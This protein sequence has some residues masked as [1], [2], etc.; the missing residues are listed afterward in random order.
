MEK[1]FD[2]KQLAG[3]LSVLVIFALELMVAVLYLCPRAVSG[4]LISVR[5]ASEDLQGI[6]IQSLVPCIL[7]A[8]LLILS[9]IH[10]RKRFASEMLLTLH[11]KW[12]RITSA[13]LGSVIIVITVYC[14]IT[15]ED[16]VSVLFSLPYYILFVAFCEEFVF[17]DVCLWLL[18]DSNK[19][20]RYLLPNTCFA[21]LHLFANTGWKEITTA[22]VLHFLTG[23]F[24]GYIAAGCIFQFITEKAGSIWISVLLHGLLDLSGII[25]Y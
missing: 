16:K 12:Q 18:R 25:Q 15:K 8:A 23:E 17:R 2:K 7:P 19:Y 21:L 3:I 5:H 22:A 9:A 20:I 1:S 14:L 6:I 10:L 4:E 11:G 13:V 24:A